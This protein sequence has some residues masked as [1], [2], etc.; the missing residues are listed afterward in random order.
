MLIGSYRG[1]PVTVTNYGVRAIPREDRQTWSRPR[2]IS[3]DSSTEMEVF[4]SRSS[5]RR[6]TDSGSTFE[7]RSSIYQSTPYLAGLEQIRRML[8]DVGYL[9]SRRGGMS[10]LTI[11]NRSA[12]RRALERMRPYVIFKRPQVEEGLALLDRLPPPRNPI[13]F[14]EICEA[15][16]DFASLNFSKSR[17]VTAETVRTAF[18]SMGFAV[19]VTT[20]PTIE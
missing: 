19:P 8:G 13:G 3:Q 12:V 9:R 11:T 7:H 6:S 5:V 17:T 4:T 14:L 20:D 15:V 1:N 2:H 16:D 18:R 10:D